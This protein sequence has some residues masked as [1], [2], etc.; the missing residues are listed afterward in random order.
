LEDVQGSCRAVVC[1]YLVGKDSGWTVSIVEFRVYLMES[2]CH[3]GS[4]DLK[5]L[6]TVSDLLDTICIRLFT[7][8][9]PKKHQLS[10]LQSRKTV[11]QTR[12]PGHSKRMNTKG[13]ETRSQDPP[14]TQKLKRP[15][16]IHAHT[17]TSSPKKYSLK[18][19]LLVAQ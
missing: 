7:E 13:A 16:F 6:R 12:K 19:I 17:H 9:I 15:L 5:C 3:L 1:S 14:W 11:P 18:N 10:S 4:P 8:F 2:K